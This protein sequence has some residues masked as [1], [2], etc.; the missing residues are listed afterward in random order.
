MIKAV[1]S[2]LARAFKLNQAPILAFSSVKDALKK[3]LDEE[4]KYESENKP[5]IS[6]Y[7]NFFNNN[8]WDVNYSG[9]QVE[10]TRKNGDY[11]LRDLFNARSPSAD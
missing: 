2:G 3:K 1:A 4:V 10:L 5:S 8:G 9:T 7:M 6:E 11:N